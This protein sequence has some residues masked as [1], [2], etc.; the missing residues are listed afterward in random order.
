VFKADGIYPIVGDRAEK[1]NVG[2]DHVKTENAGQAA[3][4]VNTFLYLSWADFSIQ[5]MYGR[6]LSSVGYDKGIGLPS[7]RA[8][9]PV[10]FAFHPSGMFTCVD[11]DTGTSSVLFRENEAQSWHEVFRAPGSG[12]RIRSMYWQDCPGTNPR[13]WIECNGELYYQEWPYLTFNPLEDSGM[14]YQWES[15]V[16]QA[17]IDMG[18]AKLAKYL[19]EMTLYTENLTTGIEIAFEYQLDEKIGSTDWEDAQSFLSSP[20]DSSSINRGEKYRIRTRFR[21][22]TDTATTPPVLIAAILEGWART[23]G[24]YQYTFETKVSAWQVDNAGEMDHNPTDVYDFLTT[25]AS[26]ARK[27]TMRCVLSFMHKKEVKV[28]YPIVYPRSWDADDGNWTGTM[29]VT[30]RDA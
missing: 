22:I 3:L 25:A 8:G 13:L 21:M 14:N 4:S 24:K 5:R 23:P 19:K 2:L 16:I 17:D 7:G 29:A 20:W 12:Q 11:A 27:V 18:A 15:V 10:W 26:K 1:M 28:E 30:L 6:D 9:K